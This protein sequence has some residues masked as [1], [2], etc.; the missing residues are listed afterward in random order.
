MATNY[1]ISVEDLKKMGLVNSN[2]D[3]KILKRCIKIVQDKRIQPAV[4]SPLYR[5][6]L[7]RVAADD[8]DAD[9][10][11]LQNEYVIPAL[12][13]LVDYKASIYLTKKIRNKG[14][15]TT[16]DEDFQPLSTDDI[17]TNKSEL[18]SDAEFYLERL[19]G[20]LKDDNG[21]KYSEY[22][23]TTDRCHHDLTKQKKGY[24]TNW[25]T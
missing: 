8:W 3:T 21:T 7:R 16:T 6:L 9:Y 5:E 14:T 18:F 20:F 24:N 12:V 1:L 15:G 19:I 22:T 13:A 4:S 25:I 17:N 2:V 11:E 23:E 10:R